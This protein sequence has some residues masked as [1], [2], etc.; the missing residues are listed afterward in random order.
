MIVV[1]RSRERPRVATQFE[2]Q[3]LTPALSPEYRG[4]GDGSLLRDGLIEEAN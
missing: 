3:P 1:V 2:V 4:E